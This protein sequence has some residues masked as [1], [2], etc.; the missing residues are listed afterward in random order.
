MFLR[1]P[2]YLLLILLSSGYLITANLLGWSPGM[3]LSRSA[4]PHAAPVR[5]K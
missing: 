3:L 2:L 5:H 4:V 1:A